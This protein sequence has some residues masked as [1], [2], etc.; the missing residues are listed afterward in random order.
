MR[1][2]WAAAVFLALVALPAGAGE[3]KPK[4]EDWA[5]PYAPEKG[6][7]LL[8]RGPWESGNGVF[9]GTVGIGSGPPRDD[10][11]IIER[12]APSTDERSLPSGREPTR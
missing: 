3:T 6:L 1:T 5:A 7:G 10:R 12:H 4:G 8:P 11:V 9:R 2:P